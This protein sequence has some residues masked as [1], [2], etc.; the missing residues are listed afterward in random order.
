MAII[1][2]NGIDFANTA[3]YAAQANKWTPA[4][5]ANAIAD[6]KTSAAQIFNAQQAQNQMDFQTHSAREAMEFNAREAQK[7][8]DWQERMSNTAYQRAVADLKAAG[9]NPILAYQQG[10]ASVG[11]GATAS[12]YAMSG[13]SGQT[14]AAQTFKSDWMEMLV[15]AITAMGMSA[16]TTFQ[17]NITSSRNNIFKFGT[18]HAGEWHTNPA[19]YRPSSK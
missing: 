10:G 5:Q 17:K 9:L 15:G 19:L 3:K 4:A 6:T 2:E 1:N 8:R 14:S 16:L 18:S 13:A 12:G 11:S 7:N